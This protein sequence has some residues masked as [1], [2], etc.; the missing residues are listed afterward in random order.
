MYEHRWHAFW[1]CMVHVAPVTVCS[2]VL[3]LNIRN[4][5]IGGELAGVSGED[6][7][8][9][10][11]LQVASK[12]LELLILSSLAATMLT[13]IFR[14][15]AFQDGLPLGAL[16]AARDISSIGFLWSSR[17]WAAVLYPKTVGPKGKKKW[18]LIPLITITTILGVFVGP[19]S[20]NLL[21][22]RV[23]DW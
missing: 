23:D 16:L 1:R 10:A 22:P 8:K 5:Y 13:Y 2:A 19:L 4:Y 6:D 14:E 15:L 21:I 9:L 17:F 12:L 11:A 18:M 3:V 7:Q 20:A